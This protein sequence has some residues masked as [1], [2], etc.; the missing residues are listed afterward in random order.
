M[1][2]LVGYVVGHI[3]EVNQRAEPGL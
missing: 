2:G 1:F 3:N